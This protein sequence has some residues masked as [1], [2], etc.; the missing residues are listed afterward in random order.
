[1]PL[2]RHLY[3][4][5][6]V[7]S[8]LQTC[9]RNGWPRAPFW[10]WEL[11]VSEEAEL[12]HTT[13]RD[14]WFRY[15]GAFDP[16]VL[17]T[18]DWLSLTLRIA[19]A[20]KSARSCD[21]AMLLARTTALPVRPDVTPLARTPAAARRRTER[22]A[23]FVAALDPDED[24]PRT[25]AAEWWIS[26]DSACRQGSRTN[27]VWLLQAAAQQISASGI[28]AALRIAARAGLGPAIEALRTAVQDTPHP[29]QQILAQTNATL[30]LCANAEER[31]RM[32]CVPTDLPMRFWR[33]EW[34]R[35]EANVGRRAT[36]IYCIPVDA[37]HRETTRGSMSR[38]F[39]NIGDVREPLLILLEGC[40]F[41]RNAAAAAGITEEEDTGAVLFP[42]DEELEAFYDKHFPDDIPDEWSGTDQA[43]SHGRGCA[44]TAPPPPPPLSIRE[45]PVSQRVWH[46]AIGV[47]SPKKLTA[48]AW[49]GRR[50]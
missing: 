28:W 45:E 29:Q 44:E 33:D 12:A 16:T 50:C 25:E 1:M 41:W 15:G 38:R 30:L 24:I 8:A 48:A 18:T 19:Q 14:A 39:T 5:D 11:L 46:M 27:A 20:I 31:E 40:T 10:M 13:L 4:L 9:L 37:L 17:A 35:W 49:R 43:K 21:A 6:E 36:R 42:T 34:A 23:A 47:R 3:E 7:V 22:S 32:L 26:F 2:T